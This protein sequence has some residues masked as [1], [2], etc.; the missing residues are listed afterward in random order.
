MDV[1]GAFGINGEATASGIA[2]TILCKP[3]GEGSRG[4][5]A[6]GTLRRGLSRRKAAKIANVILLSEFGNDAADF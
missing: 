4:I 5:M 3:F 2:F 1:T 6:Q